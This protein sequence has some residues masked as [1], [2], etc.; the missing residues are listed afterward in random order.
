M[1]HTTEAERIRINEENEVYHKSIDLDNAYQGIK[2]NRHFKHLIKAYTEDRAITL[3]Q[4]SLRTNDQDILLECRSI[5]VFLKW[6]ESITPEADSARE[7][8]NG[9]N[10]DE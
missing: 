6:L 5:A 9:V 3:A 8:L 7:S 10:T 1:Q 4:T 2:N